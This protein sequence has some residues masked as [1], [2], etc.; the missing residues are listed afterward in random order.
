MFK[1]KCYKISEIQFFVNNSILHEIAIRWLWFT[2]TDMQI[3]FQYSSYDVSSTNIREQFTWILINCYLIG[4]FM[5][6]SFLEL[7]QINFKSAARMRKIT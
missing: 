6:Y 3:L 5:Q 4:L 7:L 2:D 1:K